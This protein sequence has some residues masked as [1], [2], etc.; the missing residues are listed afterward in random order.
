[1]MKPE[2]I[3][4]AMNGIDDDIIEETEKV[5]GNARTKRNRKRFWIGGAAFAVCFAAVLL[6][7]FL[8]PEPGRQQ[9]QNDQ[10]VLSERSSGVTV[11]YAEGAEGQEGISSSSSLIALTEEELFTYHDTAVFR[12]TVAEIRN[13]EIDFNGSRECRAIAEIR[14]EKVYRGPCGEGDTVSVLLPC[15]VSEGVWVEDTEVVSRMR[16]GMAGIFMPMIYG[17]DSVWEQNG[18]VLALQDIADYGFADGTRYAF[19]ET[20]EGLV[21]DRTAYKS[22]VDASTLEDVEAYIQIMLQKTAE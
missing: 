10:I 5:R 21:F 20:E 11:R 1:M 2:N 19:L 18:A 8:A 12:G 4:D 3:S 15:P 13:I 22:I 17:G 14:V 6:A 9:S 7:V 16:P